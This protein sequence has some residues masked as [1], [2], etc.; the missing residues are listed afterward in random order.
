MHSKRL[1]LFVFNMLLLAFQAGCHVQKPNC[2]TAPQLVRAV[3]N[4]CLEGSASSKEQLHTIQ[5]TTELGQSPIWK[6]AT[7]VWRFRTHPRLF[8]VE[9][10]KYDIHRN[11]WMPCHFVLDVATDF[12]PETCMVFETGIGFYDA[13]GSPFFWSGNES[14]VEVNGAL[15]T[16]LACQATELI[17]KPFT[18]NTKQP[19]HGTPPLLTEGGPCVLKYVR[20]GNGQ[21]NMPLKVGGI[22]QVPIGTN[23]HHATF[24]FTK[25]GIDPGALVET[26]F[27]TL[28]THSPMQQP[29]QT[30]D[31]LICPSVVEKNS[32]Q[33]DTYVLQT[34]LKNWTGNVDAFAETYCLVRQN[35]QY[36]LLLVAK[37]AYQAAQAV[38]KTYAQR[39]SP[40][41]TTGPSV[42]VSPENSHNETN[43][44][45]NSAKKLSQ[46]EEREWDETCF[47]EGMSRPQV[48]EKRDTTTADWDIEIEKAINNLDA[49]LHEPLSWPHAIPTSLACSSSVYAK[50]TQQQPHNHPSGQALIKHAE[51]QNDLNNPD[52][53]CS[54]WL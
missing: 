20:K 7:R 26:I 44:D 49:W 52:V 29:V 47:S 4:P 32:M 25:S 1:G 12:V 34:G 30:Q 41:G 48:T 16:L 39:S 43:N 13:K 33:A 31:C 23:V 36:H 15:V 37:K 5:R 18:S 17:C 28:R 9:S 40:V 22:L 19:I 38:P 6:H 14:L 45:S 42:H 51:W 24:V 46:E 3:Y 53:Y 21:K 10:N 11:S 8:L 35:K 27:Q 50:N 2:M 54:V